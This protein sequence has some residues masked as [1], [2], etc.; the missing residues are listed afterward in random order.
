MFTL[1]TDIHPAR[2]IMQKNHPQSQQF[3]C[4]RF[5]LEKYSNDSLENKDN[6]LRMTKGRGIALR[7]ERLEWEEKGGKKFCLLKTLAVIAF[8]SNA[9]RKILWKKAHHANSL[10]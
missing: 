4:F 1:P 7:K 5:E 9:A 2:R 8:H 10:R 6:Y 3:H